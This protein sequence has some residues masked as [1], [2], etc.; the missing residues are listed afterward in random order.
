MQCVCDLHGPQPVV[1]GVLEVV[2]RE[3]G[4]PDVGVGHHEVA[5]AGQ[6]GVPVK[7]PTGGDVLGAGAAVTVGK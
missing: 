2:A 1:H 5:A 3:P 7:V 6:V 4:A